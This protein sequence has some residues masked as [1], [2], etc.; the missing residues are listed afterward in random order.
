MSDLDDI[1]FRESTEADDFEVGELLVRSFDYQNSKLMPDVVTTEERRM[2]LRNQAK[3][4]SVA[5]VIVGLINN[6]IVGTVTVYP[7][8]A[9][10]N[11]AWVPGAADIRYLAVEQNY[12]GRGFSE[13]FLDEA[14]RLAAA[15]GASAIC[16]HI[17]RGADGLARLYERN[18]YRREVRGDIDIL[19]VIYLEGYIMDV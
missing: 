15:H 11:E 3:K 16:L 14:R 9:D 7:P 5:T 17:R 2:D 1:T 13:R 19:P 8:G 6:R 4:R 10:G 18:G 12:L